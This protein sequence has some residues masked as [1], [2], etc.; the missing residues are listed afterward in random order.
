M[1]LGIDLDNTLIRYDEVFVEYA[2]SLNLISPDCIGSKN[3]LRELIKNAPNGQENWER[4]QGAVYGQGISSASLFPGAYRFLKRCRYRGIKVH[5]ISHKTKYAKF[6]DD[7][8]LLRS[9]ALK[10]L[11][12]VDVLNSGDQSLIQSVKFFSSREEKIQEIRRAQLDIFIDDLPEVL[13]DPILESNLR[14]IGFSP[15]NE[16]NFKDAEKCCSWSEMEVSILGEWQPSEVGL[17]A[18]EITGAVVANAHW[19]GGR[20]NS[21]VGKAFSKE[22][23]RLALKFY[24]NDVAHNRLYSEYESFRVLRKYGETQVPKCLGCCKAAE[25]ACYTW[26]DGRPVEEL[27]G[28]HLSQMIAFLGRLHRIQELPEF[29][30]FPKAS[31]AVFSGVDLERQLDSRVNEFRTSLS[32]SHKVMEFLDLSFEPTLREVV[33][34]SKR[35]WPGRDY[36]EQLPRKDWILSPSDFGTHNCLEDAVGS[37]VF[38]DFEYFGWDDPAKL[39]CDVLFHP[40]MNM[41]SPLQLEWVSKFRTLYGEMVFDRMRVM[42]GLIGLSWCLIRLNEFRRDV[43]VRRNYA[44][45]RVVREDAMRQEEKIAKTRMQLKHIKSNFKNPPFIKKG[46]I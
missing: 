23:S 26:I 6:N 9:A 5:V 15:D 36:F 18:T 37:L 39:G 21:G 22:G 34:W 35:V 16:A 10:F 14:K 7:G 3:Q 4:L 19:I 40:G 25:V 11:S 12:E 17:F 46:T 43:L 44:A 24:A 2:R 28:D 20:G 27:S 33:D 1:N 45:G 41:S 8:T 13:D 32:R 30:A 31:A 29:S 42:W 38:L